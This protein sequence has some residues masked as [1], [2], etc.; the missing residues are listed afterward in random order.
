MKIVLQIFIL[1]SFFNCKQKVS[2]ENVQIQSTVF[3]YKQPNISDIQYIEKTHGGIKYIGNINIGLSEEYFPEIDKYEFAQPI[4]YHRDTANLDTEISYFFTKNDSIIRLIEYS[5]DQDKKKE[6]F[7]DSLYQLNKKNIS[8]EL[9]MKG[10]EKSKTVD[11]WWQKIIRWD[12][13][14]MHIYSFIFGMEEGQRTRVIVRF[15]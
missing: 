6:L 7:I 12:N 10:L 3:E 2:L 9:A 1:L 11:Y 4:I 15:K 8:E 5:W 14:S 13:A